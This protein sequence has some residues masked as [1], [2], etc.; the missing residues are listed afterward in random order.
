[1]NTVGLVAD[2]IRFSCVDGPGNRF[3]VFMQGCNF[4]CIAC[5]NPYTINVCNNCGECVEVCE[6]AALSLSPAGSMSWNSE[7]CTGSD[8]CIS[9]CP[10]DSTPKALPITVSEL[11][12][13]VRGP[14]PFLSGVTVSGGEA[15]QQTP[16]VRSFF[17]ALAD[18]PKLG[19]LSRFV[20]SNGAA[21][22][23][24]WRELAPVMDGAMIDLKA[25][26]AETHLAM[27]G[28]SNDDVLASIRLLASMGKLAEVRL[29][30]LPGINDHRDVLTRTGAWLYDVDPLMHVKVIGFRCHGVRANDRL[31]SEPDSVAMSGYEE[32]LRST[33]LTRL[34]LV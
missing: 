25:L 14:A 26:D 18:D 11:I 29:L 22:E 3:V 23:H 2:V 30:L 13:Q 7:L 6:S 15:T 5:H 28:Q 10:Y 32:I 8:H 20:D 9:W 1:V 4:N 24:V 27:T 16:F 19:R 33:G 21:S 34:G 31:L 17:A 12:E